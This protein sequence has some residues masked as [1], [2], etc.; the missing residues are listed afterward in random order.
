MLLLSRLG[1]ECTAIDI[2]PV[3]LAKT[4]RRIESE[5]FKV[6]TIRGDVCGSGTD[7]GKDKWDLIGNIDFWIYT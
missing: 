7:F 2:S 5:G 4:R 1:F 6:K 3:G